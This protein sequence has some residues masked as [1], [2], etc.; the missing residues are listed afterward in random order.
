[1]AGTPVYPRNGRTLIQNM[2]AKTGLISLANMV[3]RVTYQT[4]VTDGGA[5]ITKTNLAKGDL[6]YDIDNTDW[7]ICTVAGTTV[8]PLN[9]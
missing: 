5:D 2:Y 3:R 4:G 1:M 7:Y 6:V 9:A 8:S